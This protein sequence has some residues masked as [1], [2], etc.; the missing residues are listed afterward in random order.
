M[1]SK[2]CAGFLRDNL[3]TCRT[4]R[5]YAAL[6]SRL[7]KF[8]IAELGL[9]QDNRFN[10]LD[11]SSDK[12]GWRTL[13]ATT[14]DSARHVVSVPF[15]QGSDGIFY[16]VAIVTLEGFEQEAEVLAR[17]QIQGWPP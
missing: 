15:A 10:Q 17:T 12:T 4:V 6:M 11:M 8:M 14:P 7:F 5:K 1:T 9:R 3:K 13:L 2:E 16:A